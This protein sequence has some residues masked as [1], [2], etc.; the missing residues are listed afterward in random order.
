MRGKQMPLVVESDEPFQFRGFEEESYSRGFKLIAGLDE[1][2][3]GPLAGPVVAAAVILPRGYAHPEIR[4]SKLLSAKQREKLAPLIQESTCW[5][6]GVV[7]AG[8]IDE[9]NIHQASLLAMVKALAALAS[10]PD[11]ALIDGNQSIPE[12]L[13]RVGKFLGGRK[14]FQRTIIK[15][16]RSCI[17]IAAAS[18]IAKVARDAI[19]VR[20]DQ[21]YPR[22]GFAEHKGYSCPEHFDALRRYGPSPVHRQSFKPVREASPQKTSAG[23]LFER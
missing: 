4:D 8:E 13:F 10:K 7:E 22:Y 1:V 2:G 23:P 20:L 14:M 6:I 9:L 12:P 18:I 17:S 3:R 5:G 16:D 21:L 11:C 19:M 15:G